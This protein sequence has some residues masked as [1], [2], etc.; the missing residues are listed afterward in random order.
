MHDPRFHNDLHTLRDALH[1]S[2]DKPNEYGSLVS[3][4]CCTLENCTIQSTRKFFEER[5]LE[6][7][8]LDFDGLMILVWVD[9]HIIEIPQE[10]L[11]EASAYVL[12]DTG[13]KITL[14]RKPLKFRPE[15]RAALPLR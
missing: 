6:V 5:G 8:V 9:G 3:W 12:K 10:L 15:D 7:G 11:E 13:Y 4:V 2:K 14:V 1:D